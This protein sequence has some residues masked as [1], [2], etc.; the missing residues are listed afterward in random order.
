MSGYPWAR[1]DANICHHDKIVYLKTQR[2]GWRAISAYIF[3]IGWSVGQ[4]TDGFIPTHMAPALDADKTTIA[5]LLSARLWEEGVGGW[6]IHNFAERQ[7]LEIIRES[8]RAMQQ[9]RAS[10]GNC[11]RWHGPN[12]GCWRNDLAAAQ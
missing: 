11:V 2:G 7:E 5:L 3:S 10:K 9:A 8:K 12:C 4:G 6:Q 1:L